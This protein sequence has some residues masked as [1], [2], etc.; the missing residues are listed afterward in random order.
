MP[1]MLAVVSVGSGEKKA[2]PGRKS[3]KAATEASSHWEI[4][5][6]F[7]FSALRTCSSRTP[8]CTRNSQV[9]ALSRR[10]PR[11][12]SIRER[13]RARPPWGLAPPARPVMP[14]WAVTGTPCWAHQRNTWAISSSL[15][16]KAIYSA[17]PWVRDSSLR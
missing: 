13:F 5:K 1:P 6:L 4:W 10:R 8:G 9:P 3:R 11:M 17:C 7:S 12:R 16:G 14:P 2:S 15:R